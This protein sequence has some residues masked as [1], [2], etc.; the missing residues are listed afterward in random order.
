[1]QE[2]IV[3]D[4]EREANG[5]HVPSTELPVIFVVMQT[6]KRA[7]GGV[8]SITRVIERLRRVKPIVVTQMETPVN[9]RWREAGCEVHVWPVA[10]GTKLT[11]AGA[12]AR[13]NLR[14]SRL[15]RETGCR[16]VHCNDILSLWHTAFG[17]RRGGARI[18]FNIRNVKP[19]GQRYGWRWQVARRI[20]SRQLVLS[21][22]MRDALTERLG[23][24]R[25]GSSNS[26][27]KYIYSVVDLP[28][29]RTATHAE[30][31]AARAHLGIERDCFSVGYIAA[32][33]ERKAQL[34]FIENA[35]GL[36]KQSVPSARVFFI[37]D[38]NPE[39][40]AYARRCLESVERRRMASAVSF[41]GY[42]PDIAGW[43]RALDLVVVASRNEGMARCMIESIACGTPV[44]SFDVCSAREILEGYDCGAVVPRGEYEGLVEQV[45]R[46]SQDTVTRRRLGENGVR[47]ARSLFDP[48]RLIEQY[49]ELYFSLL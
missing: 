24:G 28:D 9:E 20:S 34:E 22:E 32:F 43:Y 46:L 45:K 25:N 17:A 40:S 5:S 6:G 42:T 48:S 29:A 49:E 3:I 39:K 21:K 7:N 4:T 2:L 1:M 12:L 13:T 14:M 33:D 8:E 38:F 30:R 31:E 19:V 44:V 27:I 15:V 23:A 36:L 41:V 16:V 11:R 47:A 37:G 35:L 26:G 18:V 10:G